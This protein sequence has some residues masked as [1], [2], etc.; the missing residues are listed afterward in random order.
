MARTTT[1]T[2]TTA[3]TAATTPAPARRAHTTT[4]RHLLRVLLALLGVLAPLGVTTTAHAHAVLVESTPANGAS[5]LEAPTAITLTYN[6]NVTALPTT[7]LL[8]AGGE[9]AAT[10]N[11]DGRTVTV[12]P[13]EPL[14]DGRWSLIWQVVSSDGHL[15]GGTVRFAVGASATDTAATGWTGEADLAATDVPAPVK[16]D[17][18]LESLGWVLFILALAAFWAGRR[19]LGVSAGAL[20]AL[21]PLLRILDLLD[22]NGSAAWTVGETRAAAMAA[23]AGGTLLL[24]G[25]RHLPVRAASLVAL[26]L[27]AAQAVFSGHPNLLEPRILHTGAYAAHL[28]AAASWTAA[29]VLM[30]LRPDAVRTA[31]RIATVAVLALV[32]VSALIGVALLNGADLTAAWERT[33]LTKTAFVIAALGLGAL[34]HRALRRSP[35]ATPGRLRGRV[36]A[37]L[38]LLA[39]VAALSANLTTSTP[40]RFT[41]D[42]AGTQAAVSPAAGATMTAAAEDLIVELTFDDSTTGELLVENPVAGAATVLHLTVRDADG[43]IV[44]VEQAE[45]ELVNADAGLGGIGGNLEPSGAMAMADLTLPVPGTYRITVHVTYDTFTTV[46]AEGEFTVGAQP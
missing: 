6:E 18:A 31:S 22:R 26:G 39:G 38:V 4:P 32:P 19:T 45:Y 10:V 20:A 23:L 33:L 1:P 43:G 25:W 2:T 12:T 29:L 15:V 40:S 27:W 16:L 17:R 9:T 44:L 42:T 35:D 7:R 8:G 13:E 34:N 11:T 21:F 46:T 36:V 5:L 37:E 24:A 3:N 41:P 28:A 14:G 30:L